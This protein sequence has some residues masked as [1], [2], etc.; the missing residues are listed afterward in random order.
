[1]A[2][3]FFIKK[4]DGKL[5]PVQDYWQL[6]EWIIKNCYPLP[7]I[8]ELI[9]QVQNVKLFTKFNIR[10]GYNNICIKKGD[11]HKAAFIMNQ[12]LFE[13]TVMFFG[14]TNSPATFQ[15]MMNVIFT[16][17]IAEGWLIIYMDD[18][19]IATRD[20]PRFYE[21]CIHCRL[22]KLCLHDLYL[23]PEKCAFKRCRMEFLGVVLEDGI[24]QMDPA[25][26]KG[27]ADWLPP[28][29]VTDVC[30]FL[31]F[32]RF[33]HY[34]VPNYSN[35]AQPLIQLTKKNAVFWWTEECKVAFEWL[36][37][38]M[39]SCPILWQP[40][41]IKAFFLAT[42]ALAYSMGAILSQEGEINPH[43]HKPMLCP[44]SYYSATFTPT[45]CNY[46]IYEW[47]FLGVYMLL[48]KYRPHLAATEIPVTILTDH[49][50]LLH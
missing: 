20:D 3:F 22:E 14:L 33:Y 13:P 50:N 40:D 44:I 17:E 39:C 49:A 45:Q 4:K 12:G 7:L 10:W 21:E 9:A 23:K 30:A 35:I 28:Q 25:K 16:Q 2:P 31:G 27:I 5:Q 41:Y 47:E 34:F 24:V 11:K 42:D 29:H 48:I 38:L 36:K 6:N 15:T 26:L 1:M 19:L 18:I 37:T 43:T 46:N 8:S 32:T